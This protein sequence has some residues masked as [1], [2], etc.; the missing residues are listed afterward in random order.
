MSVFS[1]SALALVVLGLST[2]VLRAHDARGAWPP[3]ENADF[4]DQANWPNDPGYKD[5]WNYWSFLPKQDPNAPAYLEADKKI[6]ASGMSIDKAW[7]LTTGR[8]DV[9]IAVVDSGIKWDS[10]D[11]VNKALLNAVELKSYK[12]KD[13]QNQPCGGAGAM[14][15]YDCNGDGLFNVADYRDDPRFTGAVM[16]EKC[17]AGMDP[18]KPTANDRLK[19][20]LNRNCLIDPGDLILM[21]SDGKDDDGNGYT[22]DICGWDFY[23]NDNDA[24]D[25]TRY[26]HGTGEANDSVA[27]GNNMQDSIGTCPKCTFIPMRV[28]ESFITD[29]NEFGK[30]VIYAS[31]LRDPFDQNKHA[32]RVIQEALGTINQTPFSKAAIDYAYANGLTVDASMADENSRH[33][34]MPAAANHT[35]PVHSIRYDG[36]NYRNS[37][38]FLAFDS[39]TN[40][41][42]HGGVSVSGTSCASE[43]TGRMAGILGLVYSMGLSLQNPINL[44]A[45]EVMQIMKQ[46]ADDVDVL[47]SRT[48]TKDSFTFYESLPGW[49]QRFMY[50]RANAYKALKM[51]QAGRIPPEVDIVSPAWYQPIFADRVQGAV[52]I[53]GRVVAT[54]ATSYDYV[55][56]W[57][58]GVEPSDDLF[59]PLIGEVKNVPGMN[60]TGGATPLATFD[61][62][63]LDTAHVPDPDSI[64]RCNREKTFCWGPNDRTVTLRVRAVAHYGSGDVRGEARRTIAVT[65]SKNGLDDDLMPG[66][67][68]D[69][70]TSVEGSP[71]LADIDGD[72]VKEMVLPTTDGSIH[73]WS[74]KGS[75]PVELPGFPF[76]TER[77]DGLNPALAQLEPTV[78]SY[79]DAPAYKAGKNGGVDPDM[80]REAIISA[81]A[82]GD[83]DGDGKKEIVVATW[84]GTLYAIDRTGKLLPGWPKR[85]PLVPSCPLDPSKPKPMGDCMDLYHSWAR[86]TYG[87]PVLADMDK[88]GKPEIVQSAFDGNIWVFKADGSQLAGWPVRVH[89]PL[90]EKTDRVMATPAVADFNGDGIPEIVTTSNEE[91]GGG[92]QAGAV[93][94]IDGRGSA[95]PNGPYLPNWPVTRPSLR[96]FPVVATGLVASPAVA[97]FDG[98]GK[99]D[100]LIQ[101]NGAPPLVVKADPGKQPSL[102]NDPPNQLPGW[103]DP[104]SGQSGPGFA[105][106]SVFGEQTQATSPDTMFPLFS[107]PAI[108]DLDQDGVPDVVM[109]GGSL[110]LAGSLAGGGLARPF[111][112]LMAAW[113]GKTGFML[114]GSPVVIEDFTF[115][116]NHAIADINGDDYPEMIT[117]SGAYFLHAADGCGVEPKGWP[118]FTGGWIIS[119][120]AVGDLDGNGT[121]EVTSATRNGFVFAWKTPGKDSGVV[122]WASF[123]HDDANTGNF[124]TPLGQGKLK[125]APKPLVCLLPQNAPPPTQIEPGGCSCDAA[126]TPRA[127]ASWLAALGALALLRRKRS[128]SRRARR[129]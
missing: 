39:C 120:S 13:A 62:R 77:I 10:P 32:I 84:G 54:R 106:T 33:H 91:V 28:G 121:L 113:S 124:S 107:Q 12:P 72:G 23:R 26:G 81:P 22:D 58:P 118:K 88:D 11:L 30:A 41:G 96:L 8:P 48:A 108:G 25:D 29:V 114:P 94:V 82:V 16:G 46:S 111:Q 75:G 38:T 55:V 4:T 24:Y 125:A 102:S 67:P 97:D 56:E 45:E 9:G 126:G 70:G 105:P 127:D 69:V 6:G 83:L 109:S 18:K 1:R 104:M 119:T 80:A 63:Q 115:L 27:E 128:G 47:E 49:D 100:V 2:M 42:G 99:P 71:K 103:N 14:A 66:F 95:A 53:M 116:N 3:P 92:G 5:R 89:H 31:D 35:L 76:R 110:S 7:S 44:T 86:G 85:L 87:S 43:A 61:P 64:P 122:Q 60:T 101:G 93:F 98:D 117:G 90:A 20:D 52:A 15:G 57:A 123:H 79:Q 36:P 17:L 19:G 37:S 34:N 51:V 59:K 112:Q 78:P 129:P 74:L 68:V 21:F 40:Y 65:N 50:G 73:V